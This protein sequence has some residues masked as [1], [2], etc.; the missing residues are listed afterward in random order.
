[1][2]DYSNKIIVTKGGNRFLVGRKVN[3]GYNSYEIIEDFDGLLGDN[4]SCYKLNEN[5][6]DCEFKG[7][8]EN[9]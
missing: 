4:K 5:C 6:I 1:M 3:N 8:I 7:E 9:D 2:K